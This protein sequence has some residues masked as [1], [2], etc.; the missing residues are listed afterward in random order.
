MRALLVT[1]SLLVFSVA[2]AGPPVSDEKSPQTALGLSA[3]VFA[4]GAIALVAARLAEN[5]SSGLRGTLAVAGLAGIAIGPML[6]HAYAGDAWNTG[7]QIRLGSLAVVGVGAVV[8]VTSCLFK[9]SDPPGC[10]IGGGLAVI[11]LF[12]LAVGTVFEIVDAPAAARRANARHLQVIPTV[13]PGIA[14]ASIA[15]QF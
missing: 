4:G 1:A 12:G 2:H 3:G 5:E 14:G 13:G 11:G 6:G 7:L 9:P 15:G 8:V 10:G